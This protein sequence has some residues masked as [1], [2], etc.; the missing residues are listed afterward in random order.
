LAISVIVPL[1]KPGQVIGLLGRELYFLSCS[2]DVFIKYV[3]WVDSKKR[4]KQECGSFGFIPD[5]ENAN[6]NLSLSLIDLIRLETICLFQ[7]L[8][9]I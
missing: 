3:T 5:Q 9:H 1:K 7:Q 8:L 2:P 4:V 6:R